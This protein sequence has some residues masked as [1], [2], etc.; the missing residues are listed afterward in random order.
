MVFHSETDCIGTLYNN[1]SLQL[2]NFYRDICLSLESNRI[3]TIHSI[4]ECNL[5]NIVNFTNC[6]SGDILKPSKKT[7]ENKEETIWS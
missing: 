1:K 7:T 3:L 5:M 4:Q 2:W 6:N